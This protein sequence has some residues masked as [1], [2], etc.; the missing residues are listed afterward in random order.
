M[1]TM[2]KT[3]LREVMGEENIEALP[4]DKLP[5]PKVPL[6]V[7]VD[8]FIHIMTKNIFIVIIIVIIIIVVI[9]MMIII[10]ITII[11]GRAHRCSSGKFG[12]LSPKLSLPRSKAG[13]HQHHHHHHHHYQHHPCCKAG[14]VLIIF[15]FIIA[16]FII[17]IFIIII[18]IL[19]IIIILV[20][21]T[22]ISNFFSK[23]QL[24]PTHPDY[25][26]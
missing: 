18:F 20:S 7:F 1:T 9:I 4:V 24:T 8:V 15:I 14:V 10:V 25:W 11:G 6:Q 12:R 13:H 22:W 3:M 2:M 5:P 17:I 23:Y 26:Y 21:Q 16:I 19:L